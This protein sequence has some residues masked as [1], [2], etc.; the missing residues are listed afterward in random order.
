MHLLIEVGTRGEH[1]DILPRAFV[2]SPALQMDGEA[3]RG[4]P[5]DP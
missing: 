5:R 2:L 1:P 3:R 4:V